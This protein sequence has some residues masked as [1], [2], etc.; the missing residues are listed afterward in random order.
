MQAPRFLRRVNRVF[1]NRLVAPLAGFVPP[2][3]LVHH[4]G[5][6]TGRLYRSPVLAFPVEGGTLTPLPYGTDTDWLLNLL[7]AGAGELESA[8]R[9]AAVENPRVLD[10]EEAMELVPELL[11][12]LL[13]L[14]GLPGFL[15]LDRS[16]RPA[17]PRAKKR[18]PARQ[19]AATRRS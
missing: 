1:T 12:P 3:A 17:R 15:A 7:A 2:L 13:R 4:V 14:M 19:R 11:R 18:S 10:T 9:R 6:K 5:R 16:E 8:G